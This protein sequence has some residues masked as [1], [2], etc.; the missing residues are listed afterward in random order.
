MIVLLEKSSVFKECTPQELEAIANICER[1]DV[2]NDDCIFEAESPAEHLY[3]LVDGAVDLRFK[4][5]CFH[6]AKEITL[7]RIFDGEIFGWS[8][9]TGPHVYTLSASTMQASQLLRLN[10]QDL[11]RLCKDNDHLGYVLMHNLAEI[12]GER[13]ASMQ[14]MLINVI[15][16]NLKDRERTY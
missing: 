5:T 15:Q 12:I 3:M 1:M 13:L 8:S 4:L 11:R 16:E 10:A 9:L 6:S 14:R 2:K 7:E